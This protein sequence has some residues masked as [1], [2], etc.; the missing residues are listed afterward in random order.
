MSDLITAPQREFVESLRKQLHL[1]QRLLDNHC[2]ERF[3]CDAAELTKQD[4][5]VLIEE[6][7]G[8]T[9]V[10]KG[11]PPVIQREAGQTDLPGFGS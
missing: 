2:Q 11:L 7:K 5:S 9:T 1:S 3:D 10:T 8:W 6:M 4:A